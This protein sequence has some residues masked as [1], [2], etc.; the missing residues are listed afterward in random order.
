MRK[1]IT[2]I[3]GL[4]FLILAGF[5]L[6]YS[7]PDARHQLASDG[8]DHES[9]EISWQTYQNDRFG[10]QLEVPSSMRTKRQ[11][12]NGDGQVF[13]STAGSSSVQAYGRNNP[14]QLSFDA[15][16]S[17][18][19]EQMTRLRD[20]NV[21]LSTAVLFGRQNQANIIKK[22]IHRPDK[23][24]I[25]TI[26]NADS[27]LSTTTRTHILD[28]F[29]WIEPKKDTKAAP[30]TTPS[31]EQN[32]TRP[33]IYSPGTTREMVSVATP[34]P[35]QIIRSP[36]KITGEARGT[37]LYEADAP[38][39]LTNGDS[40]IIAEGTITAESSWMT[41]DFVPF[42]GALEFSRPENTG[43]QSLQGLLIIQR[44]NPSGQPENDMAVEVPVRL[45]R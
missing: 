13:V 40:Q 36:L 41:E 20:A 24:G 45:R 16:L 1:V 8:H 37:W 29:E 44:D 28:S 15:F 33:I 22:F 23:L 7:S 39:V 3:T 21:S 9:T 38:V 11:P 5:I 4:G 6:V 10:Y 18:Q 25:V 14:D 17:Q 26:K 12:T 32:S 42:S 30:T 19:T 31:A 43:S 34:T 27:K 2:T 35:D